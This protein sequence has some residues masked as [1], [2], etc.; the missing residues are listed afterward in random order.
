MFSKLGA[1]LL[2]AAVLFGSHADA[3]GR[4]G[5]R[6]DNNA[7]PSNNAP[8]ATPS[9]GAHSTSSVGQSSNDSSHNT[10]SVTPAEPVRDHG[11]IR[12]RPYY[13]QRY[14]TRGYYS[15]YPYYVAPPVY[16][17][18]APRYA[19]QYVEPA[20]QQV[21][22]V[23]EQREGRVAVGLEGHFFPQG[24]NVGATAAFEERRWGFIAQGYH[25]GLRSL[26][27]SGHLD[28]MQTASARLTYA[29]VSGP[30]GR[31]R[32][33]GGADI[34]NTPDVLMVGPTVGVSGLLNVSF[35]SF[36]ASATW[37][38]LPY[39]QLDLRAG[40]GVELGI[41]QLRAGYRAQLLSDNGMVDGVDHTELFSGPYAGI[42]LIF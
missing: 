28:T 2:L 18:D 11:H 8:S 12:V 40:M 24:G 27:G 19:P 37:T 29:L 41:L 9:G 23:E 14:Y 35:V 36:E 4:F 22:T 26:D 42:G 30:A 6:S 38:P 20:P 1:G 21:S 33:E 25:W 13:R 15:T 17:D 16:V 10:S 3:A 39:Q 7:P 5:R 32:L 34:A 31:F